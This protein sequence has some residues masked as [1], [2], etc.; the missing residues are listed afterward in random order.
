MSS[1][2]FFLPMEPAWAPKRLCSVSGLAHI[3][4]GT[5]DAHDSIYQIIAFTSH[6]LLTLIFSVSVCA[7]NPSCPVQPW[8]ELAFLLLHLFAYS[9]CG[10]FPLVICLCGTLALTKRSFR[11]GG[12]QKPTVTFVSANSFVDE[13]LLSKSQLSWMIFFKPENSG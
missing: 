7:C 5:P 12:L 1:F 10:R 13:D 11:L 2:K 8:A 3:L 9:Q 4:F 6:I